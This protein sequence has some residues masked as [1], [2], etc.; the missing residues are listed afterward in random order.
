MRESMCTPNLFT[1]NA[2]IDMH[3][4]K[5]NFNEMMEMFEDMRVRFTDL[6]S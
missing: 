4:K 2:L 5:K 6:A 1:F 3:G